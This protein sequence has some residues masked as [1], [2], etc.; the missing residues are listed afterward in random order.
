[1]RA[2]AN[3]PEVSRP[4]VVPPHRLAPP[5]TLLRATAPPPTP[6]GA[7]ASHD[8]MSPRR[9]STSGYRGIRARPSGTFY[10]EICSSDKRIGLGTFETAH[11]AA[12]AYD[13]VAWRLG[14]SRRTMSFHDVWTREQAE[15]LAPPPPA[16]TREHQQRQRE[17]EQRL[18]ITERDERLRLKWA[19]QFMEDVDAMEAF[20]AKKQEEKA[21][22]VKK[23]ADRDERRAKSA[24][25]KKERA[26][27]AA[28]KAEEKKNG[29]AKYDQKVVCTALRAA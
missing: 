6:L 1:M 13:A 11:E 15:A 10:A 28:R 23:K 16:I 29:A 26:E 18:V 24:A 19:R 27:K 4:R 7:A 12:R 14:C 3:R 20:Y 22:A 25:R 5:P 2:H 9:R 17:L 8:E 21:A